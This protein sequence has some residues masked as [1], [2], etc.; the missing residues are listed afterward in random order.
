MNWPAFAIGVV[1]G[2]LLL[3]AIVVFTVA[4]YSR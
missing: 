2:L 4:A 1:L 3:V